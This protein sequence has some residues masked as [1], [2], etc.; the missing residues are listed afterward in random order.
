MVRS[1]FFLIFLI[2]STCFSQVEVPAEHR[3]VNV[4]PGYCGWCSI[5][6]EARRLGLTQFRGMVNHRIKHK[7]V[8]G[9][10]ADTVDVEMRRHSIS[11]HMQW[12]GI[13]DARTITAALSRNRACIVFV[14]NFPKERDAHAVLVTHLTAT[15]VRFVDPNHVDEVTIKDRKW[16]DSHWN[17]F[18]MYFLP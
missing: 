3:V 14:N 16:F 8:N 10:T 13:K 5:E 4:K 18:V 2:P 6:T 9:A 11:Y 17:G 1:I 7:L 15:E 12:T